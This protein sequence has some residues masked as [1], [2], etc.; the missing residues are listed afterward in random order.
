MKAFL[1]SVFLILFVSESLAYAADPP[2]PA[3]IAL[4]TA[5]VD[6]RVSVE[7]ALKA[8]RSL[9][10][11]ATKPLTLGQIGQLCWAAQ[12]VTNDKGFRTAPSAMASY[13]LELYVIAGSVTGLAPGIYHYEP[14]KHSLKLLAVGDKRADFDEKAVNQDWI[15]RAPAIF[16]IAGVGERMETMEKLGRPFMFIE[17]GLAA[18][19]FF[20]QA[21]A[22]GLGSTFVGGFEAPEARTALGLPAAEEVLAVLPV[23]HRP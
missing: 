13:P 16:V 10:A 22:L 7:K 15:A 1:V 21:T 20:L 12:G 2:A 17:T 14:A 8:R 18:Q 11:P 6:G 3:T 19:G 4:P 23:G 5:K 9:R